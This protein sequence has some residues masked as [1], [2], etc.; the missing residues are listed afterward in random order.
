M[1]E[2]LKRLDLRIKLGSEEGMPQ[3]WAWKPCL[4]TLASA[5]MAELRRESTEANRQRAA[6]WAMRAREILCQGLGDDHPAADFVA[7]FLQGVP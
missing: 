7:R 6:S 2:I 4:Y 1:A 5:S 3:L